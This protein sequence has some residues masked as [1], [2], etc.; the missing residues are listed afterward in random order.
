[1]LLLL[2]GQLFTKIREKVAINF[3]NTKTSDANL[4]N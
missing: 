1:M 2:F 4:N 3:M